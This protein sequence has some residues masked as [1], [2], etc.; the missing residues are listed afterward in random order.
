M[1]LMKMKGLQDDK[2]QLKSL[3]EY[4][5][6]CTSWKKC[7]G[8][9]SD[10][11][12]VFGTLANM[13]ARAQTAGCVLTRRGLSV[14]STL[15][16]DRHRATVRARFE[17]TAVHVGAASEQLPGGRGVARAASSTK[18]L[19]GSHHSEGKSLDSDLAF[20]HLTSF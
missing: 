5:Y 3:L 19:P 6:N 4:M 15:L 1:T 20:H 17:Y 18:T 16:H 13:E 7:G 8:E 2:D 12:R 9:T 11:L 14:L 10:T